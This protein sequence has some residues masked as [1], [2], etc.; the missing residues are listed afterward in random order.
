MPAL[1]V[2]R[3]RLSMDAI[4]QDVRAIE[5]LGVSIERGVHV[6]RD[7]SLDQLLRENDAAF[8]ASGTALSNVLSAPGVNLAGIVQALPYLKEANLGGRPQTGRRVAV[9]G[10]GY[11]AMDAARTAVRLGAERVTVLYRRTMQETE[12]HDAERR[13]ALDE[14][15]HIEYLVSPLEFVDDGSGLVGEVICIRNQLGDLDASGR[16]RPVPVQGSEFRFPADMVILA[17]GQ[18]PDPQA[19]SSGWLDLL[20]QVQPETMMTPIQRLF[21]GG[22]FVSGPTTIIEAVGEGR[23]AADAIDAYLRARTD[24]PAS[25]PAVAWPLEV[26]PRLVPDSRNGNSHAAHDKALALDCEVELSLT[27]EAAA[28]EGLRCLYCGLPPSIVIQDCTV[29]HACVQ[30]CPVDCIRA[31]AVDEDSGVVRLANSFREAVSYDI[32]EE[33]CI[34][35]GRC[36]KACPVGAIVVEAQLN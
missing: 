28:C 34:R 26:I 17:L 31:V 35:C 18:Q 29:C 8:I 24:R 10:G 36:F 6:G 32:D 2:P 14:G 1:G 9:I 23:A 11:T 7:V 33:L 13:S 21:A 19:L 15:V 16:R 30:V 22:D 25:S 27:A 5:A 12:V 20:R 4:V 3:F